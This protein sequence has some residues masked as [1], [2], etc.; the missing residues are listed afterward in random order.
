MSGT[1][2]MLNYFGSGV[3]AA[4]PVTPLIVNGATAL[5]YAT[6]TVH[7]YMWSGT[8]AAGSWQLII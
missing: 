8:L 2:V 3:I 4:R 1:N 5:Y 7:L 6:D